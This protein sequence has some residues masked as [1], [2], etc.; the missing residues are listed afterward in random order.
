MRAFTHGAVRHEQQ[1]RVRRQVR[2]PQRLQHL[3]EPLAFRVALVAFLLIIGNARG[4]YIRLPDG[5]RQHRE[6]VSQLVREFDHHII[7]ESSNGERAMR[8]ALSP[9]C[10]KL[11]LRGI[12]RVDGH[13]S[14]SPSRAI[15]DRRT[16]I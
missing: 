9:D 10:D 6:L 1:A 8:H 14:S 12:D 3:A 7:G 13:D 16:E 11:V 5:A 4:Q 2:R 15:S